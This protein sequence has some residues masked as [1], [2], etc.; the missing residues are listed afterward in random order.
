MASREEAPS[1]HEYEL[2]HTERELERLQLQSQLVDPFTRAFFQ[3]A[4]LAP[5]M[6]VLEIGCGAGDTTLVVAELIGDGGKIVAVDNAASAVAAATTR[7]QRLGKANIVFHQADP[8]AFDPGQMFD[9]VVG[10]YVLMFNPDPASILKALL[11][12]LR[13]GGIVAFHE[14]DWNGSRSSPE[15]PLF[16]QSSDW[17]VRTFKKVG[18]NPHM[19]HQLY[20]TFL[21]SGAGAPTMALR[22]AIDGCGAPVGYVDLLAELAITMMPRMEKE[23]IIAPGD[24]DPKTLRDRMRQEVER[25]NSVVIGRSEIGAWAR[26]P[27]E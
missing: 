13:P 2:G 15:A 8:T 9:A 5:G 25:L 3:E 7:M 18:T 19:G 24:I 1:A 22:A 10:R 16:E 20:S 23:G 21:R 11:R 14:V 6:S 27:S 26:V 17:I 4:G 12:H